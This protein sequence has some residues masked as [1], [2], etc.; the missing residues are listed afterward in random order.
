M[1]DY[2]RQAEFGRVLPKSKI[3]EFA[4][5]GKVVRAR[6]VELVRE[7]VWK[8]KLS[9]ETVNLP[10]ARG[11]EEIQVFVVTVKRGDVSAAALRTVLSAIDQAILSPIFY[12]VRFGDRV[13]FVAAY[14][15][16]ADTGEVKPVIEAWFETD[17]T[18]TGPL[19][20]LP[21]AL[22]LAGLYEQ[23]LRAHIGSPA[24]AGETLREQVA[25]VGEARARE[26]EC[27]RL[28]ARLRREVQF[29][30]KVEINAALRLKKAELARLVE[31]S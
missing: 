14:K 17:W 27:R 8:Y 9:P 31:V 18:D 3:Y 30:R 11:I 28:E 19:R 24:R 5:P 26:A 4:K 15:R 16:L 2:P 12:Q 10:A 13:Q 22:D 1:F 21:L 29:N 20:P 25:R 23:M 6:F 7:V